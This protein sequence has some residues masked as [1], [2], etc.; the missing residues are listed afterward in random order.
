MPITSIDT[1]PENLT[2]TIVADFP[3]PRQQLWEAYADPRR[4]ETFWGPPEYPATF[5]RHDMFPG[6]LSHYAMTGPDGERSHGYWEFLAVEAPH[7]VEV[8]DGFAESAGVPNRDM[9]T[10]RM[11]F[12]FRETSEGSRLVTVTHFTSAEEL[13]KL[14]GM[15]MVEG[16]RAAMGQ[17]DAV[18]E[19]LTSFAADV[20]ARAQFLG[21]TQVRV[22]RVIRGDLEQ[23]WRAYHE[24]ELIRRWMLGPE[25]W[26]MTECEVANV[27]GETY[28]YAWTTDRGTDGFGF[29]GELQEVE[30]PLRDVTT[31]RMIDTEG[32]RTLNE[33]TFTPVDEGTLLTLVVTYP[34][35][36]TRDEILATGM[37]DGME[38]S[39]ARME[40]EVLAPV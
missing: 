36:A 2:L 9:P 16:T 22:S 13:E 28:R 20:P 35:V 38:L 32:P 37:V 14:V 27:V 25:G 19:D 31:E 10:M 11:V 39:Y 5:T 17:I 40:R 21:D 3:V 30:A 26:V 4:L 12:D 7:H 15:G 33:L 34:D 24:P 1:D 23:V 8:V 29:T 18:L 6:G